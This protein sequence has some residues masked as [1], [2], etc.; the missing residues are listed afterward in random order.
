M[1]IKQRMSKRLAWLLGVVVLVAIGLLVACG[2]NYSASSDGLVL[3]GSQG[4]GLIETFSF[5]L[6]TG[7]DG[8]GQ[9]YAAGYVERGMRS[10]WGAV[11]A[12]GGPGGGIC[13]R[14]HQR[15]FVV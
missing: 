12:G 3:V 15:K 4:S 8:G 2:S 9:Q 5:N 14:D 7:R 6:G 10:E 1:E 13:V 11:V